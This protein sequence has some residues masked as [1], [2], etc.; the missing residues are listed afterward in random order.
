MKV[1]KIAT[2][3]IEARAPTPGKRGPYR[4]HSNQGQEQLD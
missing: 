2:G 3:E 1:A 4:K